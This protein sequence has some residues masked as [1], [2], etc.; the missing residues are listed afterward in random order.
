MTWEQRRWL[1]K[2][3]LPI[4]SITFAADDPDSVVLWQ[5]NCLP[6]ASDSLAEAHNVHL[7]AGGRALELRVS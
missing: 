2:T 5:P 4:S 6:G 7:T 3:D 1:L